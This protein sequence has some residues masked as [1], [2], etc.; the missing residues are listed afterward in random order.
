MSPWRLPAL[1]W[2]VS[3]YF[4]IGFSAN[5]RFPRDRKMLMAD[6]VYVFLWLLFLFSTFL[7]TIKIGSVLELEREIAK[8][9]EKIHDLKHEV[10]NTLSAK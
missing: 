4:L 9:K 6:A 3:L 2:V 5:V 7:S 8:S 10:R 1:S